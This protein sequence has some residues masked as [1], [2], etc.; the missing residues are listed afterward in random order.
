MSLSFSLDSWH[1][2]LDSHGSKFRK[3]KEKPSKK[4]VQVSGKGDTPNEKIV[5][6]QLRKN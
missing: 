3:Q 1:S 5:A 2:S 6:K 4:L